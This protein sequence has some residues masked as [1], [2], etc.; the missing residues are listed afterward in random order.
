MRL[1]L[2]SALAAGVAL[3]GCF[4]DDGNPAD[5]PRSITLL[6]VEW[7]GTGQLAS[8]PFPEA[9]LGRATGG[10]GL[11]APDDGGAWQAQAYRWD[12][13]TVVVRS[14]ERIALEVFGVNGAFHDAEVEGHDAGFT[15]TRGAFTDVEFTAGGPGMY[16]IVCRTHPGSMDAWLVVLGR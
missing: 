13:G 5:D 14:G 2:L 1:W 6:A 10:Y 8:E 16:R 11:R 3:A 9:S 15:V 7:K 4:G 12:P